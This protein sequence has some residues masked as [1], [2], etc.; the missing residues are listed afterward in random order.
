MRMPNK[1]KMVELGKKA[2]K[3]YDNA[4]RALGQFAAM[5]KGIILREPKPQKEVDAGIGRA[6]WSVASGLRGLTVA[7][8]EAA[9]L[10]R[11]GSRATHFTDA[12]D[13]GQVGG[14]VEDVYR[15]IGWRLME[16]FDKEIERM[17]AS[18]AI[19]PEA[20]ASPAMVGP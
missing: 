14:S 6:I 4:D 2:E 9:V 12:A 11:I 10:A 8:P 15:I 20:S 7:E 3:A 18:P 1:K 13:C 16:A 19:D 17:A 5:R